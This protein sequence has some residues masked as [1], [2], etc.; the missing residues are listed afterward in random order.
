MAFLNKLR[1]ENVDVIS[2][3]IS[4]HSKAS[5]KLVIEKLKVTRIHRIFIADDE[6]GYLPSRV[7]SLSDILRFI[8]NKEK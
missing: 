6:T 5:L 8:L 3:A 2:P 1:Q 4:C 7:V